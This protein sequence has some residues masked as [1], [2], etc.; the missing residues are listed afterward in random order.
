MGGVLDFFKK[1]TLFSKKSLRSEGFFGFDWCSRQESNLHPSLRRAI[2]YPLKYGSAKGILRNTTRKS[3][4]FPSPVAPFD[5][6]S[7]ISETFRM[8]DFDSP[9]QEETDITVS[10]AMKTAF[11]VAAIFLGFYLLQR[12]A[13][14]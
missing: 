3:N 6:R 8:A 13:G 14:F 11:R 10:V 7:I 2:F 4:L 9:S 5:N 12:F 1:P